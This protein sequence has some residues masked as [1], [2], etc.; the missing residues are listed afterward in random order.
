MTR[1]TSFALGLIR[2]TI[3]ERCSKLA[4]WKRNISEAVSAVVDDHPPSDC[5]ECQAVWRVAQLEREL[6]SREAVAAAVT[7]LGGRVEWDVCP[8]ETIDRIS[9]LIDDDELGQA[10]DELYAAKR[11]APN[12]P[13]LVRLETM[14]YFLVTP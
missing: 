9:K 5:T 1:S 13:E 8:R 3:A 2:D 11:V 10:R 4:A 12:D 14:L 7:R 6:E